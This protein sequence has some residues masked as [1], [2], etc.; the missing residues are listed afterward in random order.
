VDGNYFSAMRI[1]LRAGRYLN[2]S[3]TADS[4]KVVVVNEAFVRKFFPGEDPIGKHIDVAWGTHAM[5]EIVGVVADSRQDTL[6]TPIA[7]SF[8]ALMQQKPELLQFFGFN[9]V[10]RTEMDPMSVFHSISEQVHQLDK[11]QALAR[12]KTMDTLVAESLAP[13]R[14]PMMLMLV[15][16]AVALF[17]AAIGIYGVLSYFVLQRR[18]EIGVRMALGAARSDVLRLVLQQGAKLIIAGI[19][20]GLAASF[21]AARAMASL[22]FDVKPTDVPTFIGVSL[23]LGILALVACAVPAFRATQVDPLVVLRNE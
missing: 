4:P 6:A 1:P 14:A 2:E 18:Q 20:I 15:F 3:D 17:L 12:V 5:S 16:G 23:V 9:L 13:R 22:L 8:Y 21:L 11:N 19:V 10:V 7:P